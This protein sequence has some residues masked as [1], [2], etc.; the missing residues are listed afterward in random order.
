MSNFNIMN[1]G[2]EQTVIVGY[3]GWFCIVNKGAVVDNKQKNS[4]GS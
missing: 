2:R 3:L 4:A 1:R